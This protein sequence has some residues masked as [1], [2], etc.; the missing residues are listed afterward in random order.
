MTKLSVFDFDGS[1]HGGLL[2]VGTYGAGD[3]IVWNNNRRIAI[4]GNAQSNVS[5]ISTTSLSVTTLANVK[6][7]RNILNER[8][9]HIY[10]TLELSELSDDR[11]NQLKRLMLN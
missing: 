1:R 3:F 8:G 7:A 5:G 11:L 9:Y 2:F 6:Q 10:D 4:Y